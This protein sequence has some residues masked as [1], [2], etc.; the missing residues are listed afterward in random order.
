MA[1]LHGLD[2]WK[3]MVNHLMDLVAITLLPPEVLVQIFCLGKVTFD[4]QI[5]VKEEKNVQG[6]RA[7]FTDFYKDSKSYECMVQDT[8]R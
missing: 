7:D 5:G 1:P 2:K 4:V 6:L 8:H 3:D